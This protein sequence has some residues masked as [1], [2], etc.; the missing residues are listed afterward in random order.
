LKRLLRIFWR[1]LWNLLVGTSLLLLLALWALRSPWLQAK[2]IPRIEVLLSDQLGAHVTIGGMDIDLPAKAVLRNVQLRDQQGRPMFAVRELRTS[3]YSLPLFSLLT[4]PFIPPKLRLNHIELIQPE[5]RLV[6]SRADSTWN[7]AFL[8]KP[9]SKKAPSKAP[10]L[11]VL[12]PQILLR[13][14]IFRMVDSTR[15]D[16]RLG[17]RDRLNYVNL[18]VR[19]ITADLGFHLHPDMRMDAELRQFSLM[20]FQSRQLLKALT[21]TLQFEPE[22][23]PSNRMKVCLQN[24]HVVTGRTDLRLD[25][26]FA[27][28]RPDSVKSGF[29]PYFQAYLRPSVF[30]FSTLNMFLPKSIP[31]SDPASVTGFVW[32]DKTGIYSDSLDAA[33]YQHT[34]VRTSMALTNYMKA[35]DLGFVFGIKAGQVSFDELQRFIQGVKL[36]LKGIAQVTGTVDGNMQRLKTN[37]LHLR[38]LDQTEL[39]VKGKVFEYTKGNDIFMDLQFKESKFSF[40]ELR[41]LIPV[42]AFPGWFD[43]F[44]TSSIDGSFVGGIS[45]FVVNAEMASAFGNISSDLHLTLSPNPDDIRYNGAI[46]T[47]HMNFVALGAELPVKSSDFNFSGTIAGQG[48]SWGKMVAEIGGE[49]VSSDIG[50]FRLDR[51]KT[52][53]LRIDH[54]RIRGKVEL[55]DPQGSASVTVNLHVPD[56]AQSYEIFGDVKGLDLAHY[57]IAPNDS[58][59]LT[60]VL[61][62]RLNGDSIENYAGKLGFNLVSLTRKGSADTTDFKNITLTSK[63]E[64][65]WRRNITLKSSIADMKLR[66]QFAYRNA[67]R[68]VSRLGKETDLYLKNNDSLT[69]VYFANKVVEPENV[70]LKDTFVT[71]PEL[72]ALLDFFRVPVHLDSGTKIIAHLDHHTDDEVSLQITSDSISVAG[73]GFKGDSLTA[74]LQKAATNNDLIGIG[75]VHVNELRVSESVVFNDVTFEPS[76]LANELQCFL[77]AFQPKQN[78]EILLSTETIFLKSGEVNTRVLAGESR[79]GV[80]GRAWYFLPNNRITRRHEHPPSLRMR[81]PDS[82]IARYA[83][84][85]LTLM[86]AGQRISLSGVVS[87]DFTDVLTASLDNVSIRSLMEIFTADTVIDGRFVKTEVKAWNLLDKQPSMYSLGEIEQFRYKNVD[88]IGIRFLGGWPYAKGPDYAGLRAEI[89]HWGEDS[90]IV[91]GW[92]NVREDELNFE[93]DS[94]TLLLQWASPFVEG[95]LENIQGKVAVDKFTIKGS[96][97]KPLLN[98]LARFSGARFKV[99]FFNNTFLLGDNAVEFDNEK[100]KIPSILVKDTLGGTA[101]LQGYVYYNDSNGVRLDLKADQ[102]RNLLLLDT[103]KQHN[104]LFYGHLVLNGDSARI[105]DYLSNAM[106]KAWVNSGDGSWLDIPLSSYTSASRLDFVHFVEGGKA[107]KVDTKAGGAAG[108][109]LALRVNARPNARVRLIFDEF[110]GDIIEARGDGNLALNIDENGDMTMFGTYIV[111]EGDYHFTLENIINKKFDIKEGGQIE[112]TGSPYE[113]DLNLEAVYEVNADVSSLVPGASGAARMPVDIGMSM[114][115]NLNRPEIALGLAP[116]SGNTQESFGLDSYFRGIQFDQQE[117]NKQV[118]SLLMFRRFT[119]SAGNASGASSSV[120]VTSS[121]SELVSNQM[122]YWLSQA[123]DDPNVGVEVNT[124]EFQDVELALRASLFNDRVTIERNGT[125]VGNANNSVSIGDISM[126]V[127]LL[128]KVDS[129]QMTD[130]F[131]GQL[132]LEFFNREDANV[133]TRNSSSQGA[134]VFFKK[135]FDRLKDLKGKKARARKRDEEDFN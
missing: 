28:I 52:D 109:R 40:T 45:D 58:I 117:L 31:M 24:G 12:L 68:L 120:N 34:R 88:S 104:E 122:N 102:I 73:I 99:N 23:S 30:D 78:N 3:L 18:D 46:R 133:T 33:L 47:S 82:L 35:D 64:G 60:T 80:K 119:G 57:N 81:Y 115:G 53:S 38:Y 42:M 10:E 43:R 92:Y 126:M 131:A 21:G 112:W 11:D 124:N 16:E 63:L 67:L 8:I 118:V 113:A 15:S 22:G 69:Q 51:I 106:I 116:G 90:V 107:L 19:A 111:T 56:S 9:S 130:P 103:R 27:D 17:R 1:S 14:G 66:G 128:P 32:G 59:L 114:K 2:L 89:G 79:L 86:N 108:F 20:E 37:D 5:A 49:L 101:N 54:H 83:V 97:H 110:V 36:P 125:I 91:K 94:S 135:D 75:F 62:V 105:T 41:K 44:G 72:N 48:T 39:F 85:D 26:D 74:T 76:A 134:G 29:D 4:Q 132:V 95:I 70:V 25:A 100:I 77:R 84:E 65:G 87:E 61:N 98:G 96:I 127:K 6:R 129:V 13:G 7:Y 55:T 71:K 121:I 123:F 93:A 50:G